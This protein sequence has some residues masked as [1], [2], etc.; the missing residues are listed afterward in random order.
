MSAQLVW[1]LRQL[2]G[3]TAVR[4]TVD[5]VPLRVPGV[6]DVQIFGEACQEDGARQR[7]DHGGRAEGDA[8]GEDAVAGKD[9]GAAPAEPVLGAE[10]L[11]VSPHVPAA[12][13]LRVERRILDSEQ[14]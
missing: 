7:P 3:I 13:R 12:H 11:E 14:A 8:S 1:T 2:G 5:G 6:G 9:G 10:S 4:I